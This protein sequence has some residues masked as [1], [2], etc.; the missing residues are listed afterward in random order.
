ML[1][2]CEVRTEMLKLLRWSYTRTGHEV[3]EGKQRYY[4]TL[5]AALPPGKRPGTHCAE[6]W[7]SPRAGLDGCGKSLAHTDV[8]SP[9]RSARSESLY[10]TLLRPTL[11]SGTN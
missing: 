6:G 10:T 8:R 9:D 3:P 2:A 11:L 4:S 7:A 5:P 1:T